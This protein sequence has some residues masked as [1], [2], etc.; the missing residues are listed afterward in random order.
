MR[1]ITVWLCW[2]MVCSKRGIWHTCLVG[3]EDNV[4]ENG[5]LSRL[6]FVCLATVSLNMAAWRACLAELANIVAEYGHMAGLFG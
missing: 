5:C 1:G 6:F 2:E 3:L 4:A